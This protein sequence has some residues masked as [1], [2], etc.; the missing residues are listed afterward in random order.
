[1][2]VEAHISSNSRKRKHLN[3]V[4][5]LNSG[6]LDLLDLDDSVSSRIEAGSEVA[7][8]PTRRRTRTRTSFQQHL[9]NENRLMS[10][11]L[12]EINEMLVESEQEIDLVQKHKARLDAMLEE[13]AEEIM[14]LQKKE[15]RLI[16]LR[17]EMMAWGAEDHRV[18]EEWEKS[19]N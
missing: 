16:S 1:M 8:A 2:S 4:S 10:R 14:L 7:K 9:G 12:G 5:D 19:D 17:E 3:V 11:W 15:I 6:E 13:S 18:T